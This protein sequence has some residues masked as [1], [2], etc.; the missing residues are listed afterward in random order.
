MIGQGTSFEGHLNTAGNIRVEG[1]VVGSIQTKAKI[2]LSHTSVVEGNIIAKTAEI[3]GEVQGAIMV[4]GLLTLKP[5]ATV[6]G[7]IMTSKLVFEEGAKFNGKCSMDSPL[8]VTGVT[9]STAVVHKENSSP[10]EPILQQV[11]L[12]KNGGKGPQ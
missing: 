11:I 5:T 9:Q 2:V 4:S 6:K 7:D 12:S 3:G 1:K 8:K 10:V